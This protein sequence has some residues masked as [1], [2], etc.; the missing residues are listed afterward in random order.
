LSRTTSAADWDEV[1]L[2][3]VVTL[4]RGYDLPSSQRRSGT[5]PIV[6]SSGITGYHNEAKISGPGVVT[7]RYGTLGEVFF[8]NEPFWPLNTT[9]YVS[10]FHGNDERFVSYFLQCQNFDKRSGAAAVPGINRN[11]LHR[12]PVRRPPLPT[13]HKIA[14]ILSTYDSLIENNNHRIE[15][16]EEVA[17]RIYREW[18]V[19][20]RYPGH[21][22]IP[23]VESKLGPI[24]QGWKVTSVGSVTPILG[25]GT[26]SK[27]VPEYWQDGT[28]IWYTPTDL[29]A[30]HAMFM[31]TSKTK[32]TEQ[33]LAR[34]SAKL[35]P[36]G[37]VMMTSR[38]TIGVVSIATVPA[39]TNQGFIT[40]P[41]S[42]YVGSFHLYFWLLQQKDLITSLA[43]GATFKEINKAVFRQILFLRAETG[44]ESKFENVIAP[45]GQQIQNLL[46][47]QQNLRTTRNL[48]VPRLVSGEIDVSDLDIAMPEDAA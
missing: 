42:E 2:G 27:K 46:K 36:A 4:H 13:Q 31:L 19:D 44:I 21:E 23:L 5:V 14:A 15:I 9:L 28:V 1:E 6:S 34:S 20:F 38:A 33:G 22:D 39:A 29:T 26:P 3:D 17:Q 10:D 25:G 37:S 7:G 48:L 40:C 8:V 47:A 18:F 11:V 12:L 24:P 45:I 35:F 32:I 16:L 41:P 30:A 43:T